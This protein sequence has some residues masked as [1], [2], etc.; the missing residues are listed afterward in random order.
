M[1]KPDFKKLQEKWYAKLKRE[2][3][4]DQEDENGNL[5]EHS[6]RFYTKAHRNQAGGWQ[7]KAE[8]YQLASQFLLEYKFNNER[9]RIIWEYHS[10]GISTYDIAATLKK[11][12]VKKMSRRTINNIIINLKKSMYAMYLAHKQEYHE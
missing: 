8:Y 6:A 7:A 9:E 12:R 11:A 1:A 2:G 5:K 3:F 10:N 4:E